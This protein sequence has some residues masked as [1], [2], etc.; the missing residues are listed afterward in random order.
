M[1]MTRFACLP[2]CVGTTLLLAMPPKKSS[3]PRHRGSPSALSPVDPSPGTGRRQVFNPDAIAALALA[4]RAREVEALDLPVLRTSPPGPGGRSGPQSPEST[5][6]P[7]RSRL[8]ETLA[9][10]RTEAQ[11]LSS[12]GGLSPSLSQRQSPLL[13]S[14]T[15]TGGRGPSLRQSLSTSPPGPVRRP[16]PSLPTAP[17][18]LALACEVTEPVPLLVLGDLDTSIRGLTVTVRRTE[19]PGLRLDSPRTDSVV[20]GTGTARSLVSQESDSSRS[21]VDTSR[22]RVSLEPDS[23]RSVINRPSAPTPGRFR[24]HH[25]S[26]S[27]GAG[28]GEDDSQ[29]GAMHHSFSA[30][31]VSTVASAGGSSLATCVTYDNGP[32]RVLLSLEDGDAEDSAPARVFPADGVGEPQVLVPRSANTC[33]IEAHASVLLVADAAARQPKTIRVLQ[34]PGGKEICRLALLGPA[35]VGEASE[36]DLQVLVE[37]NPDADLPQEPSS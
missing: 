33:W 1:T 11:A 35:Q 13:G 25:S 27:S 18:S 6:S 5:P 37:D 24:R 30:L 4:R 17:Q 36:S 15:G 2:L 31:S 16:L 7:T 20:P 12:P 3:P 28:A 19:P 32:E 21:Q 9:L 10:G 14:L 26:T 23:A 8:A 22:S 29:Y 34:A